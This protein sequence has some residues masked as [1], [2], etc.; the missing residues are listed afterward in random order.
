MPMDVHPFAE[1]QG[2]APPVQWLSSQLVCT[3]VCIAI[4]LVLLLVVPDFWTPD[5]TPSG[6]LIDAASR[7]FPV[8]N[9]TSQPTPPAKQALRGTATVVDRQDIRSF[10]FDLG[11]SSCAP[12]GD[13]QR[14]KR[15]FIRGRHV[16]FFVSNGI[17]KWRMH[18]HDKHEVC[19]ARAA[20]R[21]HCDSRHNVRAGKCDCATDMP[22]WLRA[23]QHHLPPLC[24]GNVQR[25]LGDAM[26]Q[27][28]EWILFE[29]EQLY[30][31]RTLWTQ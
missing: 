7:L 6:E 13:S 17:Y 1:I 3:V 11:G 30:H 31:L 16:S 10:G 28:C 2:T 15:A 8:C 20:H 21:Q 4:F 14:D 19:G 27:L 18:A 5:T 26:Y 12:P 23:C 22:G 24:P 25:I 9:H 29:F